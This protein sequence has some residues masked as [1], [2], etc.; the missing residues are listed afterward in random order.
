MFKSLII[1]FQ[2]RFLFYMEFNTTLWP[3]GNWDCLTVSILLNFV[4]FQTKMTSS[5][6]LIGDGPWPPAPCLCLEVAR[7]RSSASVQTCIMK[8]SN[9]KE[10]IRVY[11][12]RIKKFFLFTLISHEQILHAERFVE[13]NLSCCHNSCYFPCRSTYLLILVLEKPMLTIG[14]V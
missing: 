9:N 6:L 4:A 2:H 3:S 7:W 1:L 14:F 13:D 10:N 5:K 8:H 11:W 12:H